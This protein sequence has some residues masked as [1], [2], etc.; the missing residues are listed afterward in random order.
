MKSHKFISP[1]VQLSTEDIKNLPKEVVAAISRN[2]TLK[3]IKFVL[4]DDSP[5]ANEQRIPKEEF[6]NLVKTG[7]HMPIKM[8]QGF[9]REGHEFSVPIG[10]I[11][12]L[13]ERDNFVE[14]IAGLWQK[15]F[16]DEIELL[17]ERASS[18]IKPQLSWEILYQSSTLDDNGIETFEG[19]ML[20]AATFVESPA[21]EG[22]TP[23]VVM[24]SKQKAQGQDYKIVTEDYN[25]MEEQL[26]ALEIELAK[27][28]GESESLTS[29]LATL[30]E[31]FDA[32]ET[33]K[34]ELT[35]SNEEL[36][37][38]KSEIEEALAQ[39]AKLEALTEL[40]SK[41]EV[42]LPDDYLEDEE[43]REQLLAMDLNDVEFLI[44]DLSSFA[45]GEEE[46]EVDGG[47]KGSAGKKRLGSKDAA[48]NLDGVKSKDWT[49][50]EI[51]KAMREDKEKS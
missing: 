44:R 9:I 21:Y 11:T 2:P 40:F 13:V 51:A 17:K 46:D 27:A 14:G 4:T 31:S 29:D 48:P 8:A 28:R 45:S 36:S 47:K 15:E 16:P 7:V 6:A 20:E 50:E 5:N 22:R 30:Q 43:K 24:A 18:D 32:L 33:E 12:N 1:I 38:Y 19:V 26:K 23:V 35:T 39:E 37:A 10:S 25:N 41:S 34:G 3:W 42:R 49:P